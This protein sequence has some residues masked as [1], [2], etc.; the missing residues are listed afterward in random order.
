[1]SLE[2]KVANG[3]PACKHATIERHEDYLGQPCWYMGECSLGHNQT[4]GINCKYF[5]NGEP[6]KKD[7]R[8]SG[9]IHFNI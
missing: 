7:C 2:Y 9:D 5:E 6:I 3:C 8:L 1:M 4:K